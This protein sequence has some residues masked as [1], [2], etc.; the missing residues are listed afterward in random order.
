MASDAVGNW[1]RQ[2]ASDLRLAELAS[3]HALYDGACYH[4]QQC[5]EKALKAVL[6]H[7]D[8]AAPWGHA[9]HELALRINTLFDT[10]VFTDDDIDD[11]KVLAQFVAS[12][13]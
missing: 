12:A 4:A 11:F 1:M 6:I 2:A 3:A 8:E 13:R 5:A 9:V 7:V 10:S